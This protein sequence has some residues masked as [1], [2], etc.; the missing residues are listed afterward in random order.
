[1][2]EYL[3]VE[4]ARR[5]L[6]H[7]ESISAKWLMF[8]EPAE[9][10]KYFQQKTRSCHARGHTT[11]HFDGYVREKHGAKMGKNYLRQETY[12]HCSQSVLIPLSLT[13]SK[14]LVGKTKHFVPWYD[15]HKRE[16]KRTLYIESS[17]LEKI[18]VS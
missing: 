13:E 12:T 14:A 8:L 15:L 18:A 11:R 6:G 2:S 5:S 3:R 1:M 4:N 7:H 10:V 16:S 17:S 9:W